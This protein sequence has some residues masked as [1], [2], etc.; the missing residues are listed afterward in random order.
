[1]SLERLD[2]LTPDPKNARAHG[3]RNRR[4][5][6]DALREVGPARSIVVDEHG[7]VL[8]GN[9]TVEAARAQGITRVIPVEAAPDAL[10]AVVRRGLTEAEKQRLALYDNRAAEL[11][12]WD[13]AVIA[14]LVSTDRAMLDGLFTAPELQRILDRVGPAWEGGED[15]QQATREAMQAKWGTAVGQVWTVPSPTTPGAPH[16]VACGDAGD[17]DLIARLLD[18]ARPDGIVSD[19]PYELPLERLR[20]ILEPLAPRAV[21]MLGGRQAFTFLQ[22]GPWEFHLDLIWRHRAP[23]L[24]RF[25]AKG[26]PVLYHANI[27]LVSKP[28]VPLGW[29]R[30]STD[31]AS[32]IDLPVPDYVPGV[33]HGKAAEVFVEMLRGFALPTWIDP[34]LGSG[35][36]VIAGEALGK[37]VFGV[38]LD[39]GRF[40]V[41]LERLA[42]FGLEPRL[43]D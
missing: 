21:L 39:P 38:E 7:R 29:R 41:A 30:P 22:A 28:R 40:G 33:G 17:G 20:A 9:G 36:S 24:G 15:P 37:R 12:T 11:A 1:V 14:G 8:A 10:V 16:R 4:M 2:Q 13:P 26:I 18:G 6:G 5:I 25:S 19:P 32:I 42:G 23:R 3:E 34:F 43:V 27:L 31:F 35:P